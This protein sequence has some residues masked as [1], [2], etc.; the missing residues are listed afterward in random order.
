MTSV[1][2]T[3]LG[4]LFASTCSTE[5]STTSLSEIG[6]SSLQLLGPLLWHGQ[7]PPVLLERWDQ[8]KCNVDQ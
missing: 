6:F 3:T 4:S 8:E 7:L 5:I 2:S 1:T